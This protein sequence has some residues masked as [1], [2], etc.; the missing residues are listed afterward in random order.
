ME[1]SCNTS[2]EGGA[3]VWGGLLA[4]PGETLEPRSHA[5]SSPPSSPP[6]PCSTVRALSPRADSNPSSSPAVFRGR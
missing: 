6:T 3:G 1:M 4:G 5:L 2:E